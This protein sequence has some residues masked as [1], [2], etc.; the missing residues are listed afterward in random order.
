MKPLLTILFV[1]SA[2]S[3]ATNARAQLI[4][5]EIPIPEGRSSCDGIDINEV[6]VVLIKCWVTDPASSHHFVW[7]NSTLTQVAFQFVE[8]ERQFCWNINDLGQ[9][10]CTETRTDT[11]GVVARA[12][13][14]HSDGSPRTDLPLTQAFAVNDLGDVYGVINPGLRGIWRSFDST[15]VPLPGSYTTW[16]G[17]PALLDNH[18]S[19]NAGQALSLVDGVVG[20]LSETGFG[21]FNSQPQWDGVVAGI[22]PANLVARN[23]AG[24]VAGSVTREGS[25]RGVIFVPGEGWS[26]LA[27]PAVKGTLTQYWAHGINALGQATGVAWFSVS[28]GSFGHRG[29]V[30]ATPAN[31]L[32]LVMS[33]DSMHTFGAVS[34]SAGQVVGMAVSFSAPFHRAAVL[35]SI[36]APPPPTP[37]QKID[38]VEAKMYTMLTS[39]GLSQN[40][41]NSLFVKLEAAETAMEKNE[42]AAAKNILNATANQVSALVKSKRI[43]V[44]NGDVLLGS[45]TQAIASF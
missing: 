39:G 16:H 31:P 36:P 42:T 24:V 15:L 8:S 18:R 14:W 13:V 37:Q 33:D 27:A 5:T 43:S 25:R 40:D 10:G 19:V 7:Q 29:I 4:G 22:I 12:Y 44:A 26:D 35:W 23:D 32:T 38:A 17:G 6:G 34:N 45:I 9:V 1:V 20:T 3:V 21:P 41:A 2:L 28:E 11:S 30:W